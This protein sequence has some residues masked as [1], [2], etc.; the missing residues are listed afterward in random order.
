MSR[1]FRTANYEE[2]LNETIRLGDALPPDHLARF[3]V[4]LVA[5]LDL[6]GIYGQYAPVGGE[7]LAPEILLGLLFYGYATGVFSSRKIEKATYEN[8]PFRFIAGGLHPD[9]DTI[10][11]FRKTFLAEIQELFVQILLVAQAAGVL[12]LGNLSLDGS[13]IHADASKSH[14]VSYGRLVELEM[15]L[16]QEVQALLS[17]GEQADQG[18]VALPEGLILEDELNLRQ[19]RLVNLGQARKVLEERANERYAAEKAEYEAKMKERTQKARKRHHKPKGRPAKAP[20]PGPRDKDQYNFSDPDSRIMKNSTNDGFDQHYNVQVAA[21]QESMLIVAHMLSNHPN[22]KQEAL[23]T[24]KAIAP[25][26]G[27]P[28]AVALDNG[29]FSDANIQGCEQLGIEPYI[30]TGREPHHLDW[31]TFFQQQPETPADEASAIVKMAYKLQTE[32]GK[33]IYR[34]RKCTIEPV[35][36]IIKEILGFRQFSLRGL[37]AAAGEW[38]LVCLAF[39]LK[40]MHT[41]YLEQGL[42]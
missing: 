30:A 4:D 26:L 27:Q 42:L 21:D 7:A 13:K 6:S 14:A 31:R 12:K 37:T 32:I 15:E 10:A 18:E 20:E 8:I 19:A 2:T 5:A 24:L 17:L 9:H 23:P 39:N 25:E 33:A 35:I 3:V 1:K 22:D 41:L 16:T 36:G 40:R 38:C 34:L 11:N 29:Y 28:D